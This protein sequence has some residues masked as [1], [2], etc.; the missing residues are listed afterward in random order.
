[1][2]TPTLLGQGLYS[3]PEAARII[4]TYPQNLKRWSGGYSFDLRQGQ[5]GAS[6]P[7]LLT[8]VLRIEGRPTLTFQQ[9]VELYFVGLFRSKG[10]KL[11]VIR[12][13]AKRVSRLFGTQ[14]PFA[15]KGLATDRQ[16]IFHIDPSEV[17]DLDCAAATENLALGQMVIG[18]F[19]E[20]YLLKLEYD[21]VEATRFWPLGHGRRIAMDPQRSFG[22]AIDVKSGVPANVL[23]R[24]VKAGESIADVA[25]WYGVEQEAVADA[26]EFGSQLGYKHALPLAA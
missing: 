4:H 9:L 11:P 14:H 26:V 21:S 5:R 1:M 2:N 12:A 6:R 18:E 8:E 3:L 16:Q 15:A 17:D 22:Q 10:V 13:A 7:V 25:D 20:P 24:M 19:L 23:S